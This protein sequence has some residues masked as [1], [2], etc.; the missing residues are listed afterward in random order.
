MSHALTFFHHAEIERHH[1]GVC[2]AY[3]SDEQQDLVLS[4]WKLIHHGT[5]KEGRHGRLTRKQAAFCQDISPDFG[6]VGK[7]NWRVLGKLG[8]GGASGEKWQAKASYLS[9]VKSI[10]TANSR[11]TK[12]YD[13]TV[14]QVAESLEVTH[15]CS[16][17][18]VKR[19]HIS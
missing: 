4:V 9:L 15:F 19:T 17:F 6:E 7:V 2:Q 11:P 14:R 12:S 3:A 5:P 1:D 16:V 8:R 10:R 18:Q 13:A